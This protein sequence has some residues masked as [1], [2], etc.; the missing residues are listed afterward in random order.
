MTRTAR[1]P[2]T[3][4][5]CSQEYTAFAIYGI[6][7][8]EKKRLVGALSKEAWN[9]IMTIANEVPE[10]PMTES[11]V[12]EVLYQN[13]LDINDDTR[14]APQQ[15]EEHDPECLHNKCCRFDCDEGDYDHPCPHRISTYWPPASPALA[16]HDCEGKC[17]F[18]SSGRK[19]IAP[20]DERI[21]M[22]CVPDILKGFVEKLT[23]IGDSC[24]HCDLLD[25]C[26]ISDE[27][28]AIRQAQQERE[29]G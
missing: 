26:P 1:E 8:D 23:E 22:G 5:H 29:Q 28:A 9:I 13:F 7:D 3:Q 14:P 19:C 10:K 4:P 25:R 15:P 2:D 18:W 16:E 21:R 12:I 24:P 27:I 11:Q 20:L 17:S 6:I